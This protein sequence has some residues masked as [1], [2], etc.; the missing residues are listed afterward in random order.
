LRP[1]HNFVMRVLNMKFFIDCEFDGFKGE[2]ISFAMVPQIEGLS[3]T[4]Y[5]I[6]KD[7]AQDEWVAKNVIPVLHDCVTPFIYTDKKVVA[8]R[9]AEIFSMFEHIN[10]IADWPAD[11]KHFCDLIEINGG[12]CPAMQNISFYLHWGITS[13]DSAV[14]HNALHDAKAIAKS[15]IVATA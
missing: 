11:I 9:I 4:I 12:E 1:I 10:I 8:N 2:L 14:P 15:Y 5:A 13:K 6:F 7:S 3:P